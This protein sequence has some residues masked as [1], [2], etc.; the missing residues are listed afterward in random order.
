MFATVQQRLKKSNAWTLLAPSSPFL[1]ASI[2]ME[3]C[4]Y[5]SDFLHRHIIAQESLVRR[6]DFFEIFRSHQRTEFW[7]FLLFLGT[8]TFNGFETV[9]ASLFDGTLFFGKS[10]LL[11]MTSALA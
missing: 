2:V 9:G 6:F 4:F 1:G 3:D 11:M 7:L 10:N 8:F 5:I